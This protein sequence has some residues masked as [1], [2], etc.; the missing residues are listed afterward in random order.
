[1]SLVIHRKLL[2]TALICLLLYQVGTWIT[3]V[4]GAVWGA[5]AAL[6]VAIVSYFCARLAKRGANSTLW[7]ILPTLLFTGV[8]LCIKVW[9]LFNTE[10]DWMDAGLDLVPLLV[11]F[12]VPVALLS[13]VYL[14]LR[15]KTLLA[16]AHSP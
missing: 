7:F 12:V 16:D 13:V 11:G 4:A 14:D 1:M 15:K 5:G 3:V 9:R 6:V 8:P 10:A 2:L